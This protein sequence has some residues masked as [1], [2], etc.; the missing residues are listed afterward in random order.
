[1]KL[2]LGSWVKLGPSP[3]KLTVELGEGGSLAEIDFN[4]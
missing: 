3:K 1:M 2:Q 4:W